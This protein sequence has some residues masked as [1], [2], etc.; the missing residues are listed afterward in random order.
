M[1]LLLHRGHVT[2]C[3]HAILLWKRNTCGK[4]GRLLDRHVSGLRDLGIVCHLDLWLLKRSGA[5]AENVLLTQSVGLSLL[6]M[7][8]G[9]HDVIR[10][11]LGA[12][13]NI[14]QTKY[15]PFVVNGTTTN[16]AISL[17]PVYICPALTTIQMATV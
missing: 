16:W 14:V 15:T 8:P 1:L 10:S 7:S 12:C 5:E 3:L 13:V 2:G 11:C 6:L 9:L 4:V 17:V